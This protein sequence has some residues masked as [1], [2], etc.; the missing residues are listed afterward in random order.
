MATLIE[1][2]TASRND[3][4][5]RTSLV[6]L[7]VGQV[8]SS[9]LASTYGGSFTTANRPGEPLIVPPGPFFS[10]WGVIIAISIGYA[11]WAW[12]ARQPD[13]EL[14]NALARPLLVVVA[15]F[16]LWLAAAELEPLWSTLVVFVGMLAGLLWALHIALTH[17]AE[18]GRW[19]L[20]GR[21]LLWGTLGLY[22]G[23]ASIAIWLNLTTTVSSIGAPITGPVGV[24]GQLAILAG[25]T[26]TAVFLVRYTDGLLP[27]AAA[28]GWAL[29]GAA[30]GSYDAGSLVLAVVSAAGLLVLLVALG[31]QRRQ[32]LGRRASTSAT[33]AAMS[34]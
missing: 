20:L 8:V 1:T 34:G 23:W 14:R 21:G 27:Y 30:L 7:A 16:S 9:F 4:L 17:R 15:T 18:I 22:T 29:G 11:I 33:P 32:R 10:I 25:A 19:S 2:R 6:V 31:L 24:A 28:A 26:A 5:V 3:L 12:F 13:L